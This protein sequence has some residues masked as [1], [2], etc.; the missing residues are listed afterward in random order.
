MR[1]DHQNKLCQHAACVADPQVADG[2]A[3]NIDSTGQVAL[4]N[5][6]QFRSLEFD[7]TNNSYIV[8]FLQPASLA[9]DAQNFIIQSEDGNSK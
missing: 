8:H 4:E 3:I 6:D 1:T 7:A 5:Q 2:F 9:A